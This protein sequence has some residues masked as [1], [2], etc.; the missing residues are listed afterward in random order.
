MAKIKEQLPSPPQAEESSSDEEAEKVLDDLANSDEESPENADKMDAD[1]DSD[2]DFDFNEED[3][4]MLAK[5]DPEFHAWMKKQHPNLLEA[6]EDSEDEADEAEAEKKAELEAFGGMDESGGDFED[7]TDVADE[8]PGA[9]EEE[10]ES[11]G[12][13]SIDEKFL[14][15]LMKGLEKEGVKN[16]VR[17]FNK[18]VGVL[19]GAV[20]FVSQGDEAAKRSKEIQIQ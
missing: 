11:G 14:E 12:P 3:A 4:E 18:I 2:E 10:G 7:E 15:D 8:Q 19:V 5:S 17:A 1:A 20:E 16:H 6:V 13:K 9:F